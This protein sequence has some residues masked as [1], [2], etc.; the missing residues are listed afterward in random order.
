M[1]PSASLELAKYALLMFGIILAVGTFSGLIARL[2]RVPDVVVFLL[3]GML[4]GPSVMGLVGIKADSAINQLILIFG[5]SYILFD[6]GASIRLK[7]LKEVWITIV[8]ISTIG[9]LITG[10]ITGVAAYYFLGVPAI[11][12][13]LLGA[14][15]ASTDPSTLVPIFK[16]I[17]IKERVAQAV[18]SESAFNDAMGAILTFT[19]LAVAMGAGKFSAGDALIDL[20]KQSLLGILIGGVLGYMAAFLISHQKFGFLAEYAPVVTLMAVIGAYM[21]ADGL[22]S[23]GFMAVFV[24]GILLGNQESLGFKRIHH[25]EKIL[26]DFIMTTAQIMRMFIFILLGAQVDFALMNQY[27]LGGAA[28]VAVFMLVARPVTVFLCTLPDRRAKWSFKE[29]LF[30]CWTRETGVIPGALAGML[31]GMKAPG[32]QII[33]SVTFIAILMTI[34]IQ[35]TTT[36]WLAKKLDLLVEK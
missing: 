10:A 2:L 35:A 15:L 6:G 34:L 20:L 31:A 23:S 1:E 32:A 7:V 36:K 21:S 28:V 33:A 26:E 25:D 12:A 4:V 30:M 13:L 29:M 24:F 5:S 18:M 17:K 8:V 14:V 22:H 19:V 16:Q 27:L 11:V 3:V 9:V